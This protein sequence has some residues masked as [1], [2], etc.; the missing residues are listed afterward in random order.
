MRSLLHFNRY[1]VGHKN[2]GC[3]DT[4]PDGKSGME[5]FNKPQ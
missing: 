3:D 5:G 4:V 1:E 2:T